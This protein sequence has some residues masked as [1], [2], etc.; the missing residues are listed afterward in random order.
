M[1]WKNV[2]RASMY[3]REYPMLIRCIVDAERGV[4]MKNLSPK[5]A[6]TILE[7]MRID[8]LVP[9]AAVMQTKRNVALDMAID[10]LKCSEIPNGSDSI[11][12][13]AAVEAIF[14]EPLYESGMKKRDAD[15]VVPAIYEKIKSLPSAQPE[16]CVDA[17]SR[18]A[19]VSRISDLLMLELMGE[20]L[21][22]W[23]EVYRAVGELPT[24]KPEPQWIPFKRRK[25]TEEEGTKFD[26]ILDCKLPENGQ[27][28]LVSIIVPG[29][30][31][32]QYDTYWGGNGDE[33][34]LDSGYEI[35]EEAIA[36]MPLPAPYKE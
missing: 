24:V 10:A 3:I 19:V 5:E 30:E 22:T 21:P 31:H 8:I 9:K 16:P 36:W 13:Q 18:R 26:Y 4:G 27:N 29:H 11:S 33:C 28:I 17:V 12:R 2:I 35:V 7:G 6:I 1:H 32:V 15:A 25:P 14:S 34:F 23:N 20:R